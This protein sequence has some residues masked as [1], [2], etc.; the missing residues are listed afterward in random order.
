M[1]KKLLVFHHVDLDGY[2]VKAIGRIYGTLKGY[3]EDQIVF[4]KSDYYGYYL[5]D[6]KI[7]EYLKGKEDEYAE[8]VFGDISVTEPE[9]GEYLNELS[10]KIPIILRDH[11]H[12]AIWMNKYEWAKVREEDENGIARCGTYW[13]AEALLSKE[14]IESHPNLK[15]FIYLTDMMD[16]WKWASE[17]P[18]LTD[19]IDLSLIMG[20][21]G[22]DDFD[23][24]IYSKLLREDKVD[25]L[26]ENMQFLLKYLKIRIKSETKSANYNKRI[27]SYSYIEN[28]VNIPLKL[29]VINAP[30]HGF[31]VAQNI[32]ELLKKAKI[33]YDAILIYS[34]KNGLSIK[35]D[36]GC[37]VSAD[38]LIKVFGINGGGHPGAAGG[39]VDSTKI[40][41]AYEAVFEGAKVIK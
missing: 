15:E 13:L 26:D 7:D 12:S 36:A 25:L 23:E 4:V 34:F 11:H 35:A 28:G 27:M 8:V 18:Q 14:Y 37:K 22:M 10:K 40:D 16:T 3:T 21:I 29:V 5:C 33:D 2:G 9:T 19:A 20:E 38:K 6:K 30:S 31:T 39:S 41:K 1:D 17:T 32:S 24:C